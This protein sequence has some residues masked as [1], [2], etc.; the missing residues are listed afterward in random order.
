MN[1]LLSPKRLFNMK[2]TEGG[3]NS[4]RSRSLCKHFHTLAAA[5]TISDHVWILE[6]HYPVAGDICNTTFT[7]SFGT[8][9][10]AYETI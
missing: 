4:E 9:R 3:S 5:L 10:G 7:L 1:T 8:R 2:A 6:A